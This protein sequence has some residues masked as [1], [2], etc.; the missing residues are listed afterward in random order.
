MPSEQAALI[1]TEQE[2]ASLDDLLFHSISSD[3][4]MVPNAREPQD[5]SIRHITDATLMGVDDVPMLALMD[6]RG[7]L[8][9][10]GY[11]VWTDREDDGHMDEV[12]DSVAAWFEDLD[13]DRVYTSDAKLEK[14]L[15]ASADLPPFISVVEE[16]QGDD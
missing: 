10:S 11:Y 13:G 14:L 4:E 8:Q 9:A 15:P 6:A 1:L 7:T 5:F 2:F 3:Y 12:I 16:N